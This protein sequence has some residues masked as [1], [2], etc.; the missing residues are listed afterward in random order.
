MNALW[1]L[2]NN[3]TDILCL[4]MDNRISLLVTVSDLIQRLVC[5]ISK[6]IFPVQSVSPI[7]KSS[8]H[9]TIFVQ[10]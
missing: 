8:P 10:Q 7:H 5:R 9:F 3:R 4:L 1:V 6:K 2:K